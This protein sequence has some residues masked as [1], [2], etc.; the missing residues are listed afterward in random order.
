MYLGVDTSPHQSAIQ[1]S[2]HAVIFHTKHASMYLRHARCKN[3]YIL[4]MGVKNVIG[5]KT[6]FS[7]KLQ[8]YDKSVLLDMYKMNI[9][10]K[11]LMCRGTGM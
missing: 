9:C 4:H 1:Y 2:S 7:S 11:M 6:G 3:C 10:Y 8:R 5:F